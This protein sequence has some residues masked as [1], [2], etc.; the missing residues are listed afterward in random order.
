MV[1]EA[2]KWGKSAIIVNKCAAQ[3]EKLI[4]K[5][6]KNF[7]KMKK[8]ILQLLLLFKWPLLEPKMFIVHYICL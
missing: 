3:L 1:H 8:N 7:G 6:S 2:K 5:Y 4:I